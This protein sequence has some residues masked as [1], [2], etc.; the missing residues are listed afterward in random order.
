MLAP[1]SEPLSQQLLLL[2]APNLHNLNVLIIYLS[3]ISTNHNAPRPARAVAIGCA[4]E[5]GAGAQEFL[6]DL[7]YL[8]AAGQRRN[9]RRASEMASQLCQQGRRWLLKESGLG[10]CCIVHPNKFDH[11][12][13]RF[14]VA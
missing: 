6:G 7:I 11:Y 1:S 4:A 13:M 8:G 5:D 9:P 12:S 10:L 3:S 2:P 14:I